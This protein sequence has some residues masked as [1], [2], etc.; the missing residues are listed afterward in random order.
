MMQRIG[1]IGLGAMGYP[2]AVNLN[3]AGFDVLGLDINADALDRFVSEGG[4]AAASLR[5]IVQHSDVVA[6]MLPTGIEVRECVHELIE[7]GLADTV[8]IDFSTIGVEGATEIHRLAGQHGIRVMDAPVS[9]GV[10]GAER[11]TL[12]VMVGGD[13]DDFEQI[14]PV[15][16]AVG[17]AVTYT[18]GP[19]CGQAVKI[20]NNMAAGIIKVAVAEAFALAQRLGVDKQ[21]LFDVASKSSANC[22]ALTTTCPV[23]GLVPSAPSSHDYEGGF[24]TRLMLKDMKLAQAAAATYGVPVALAS[25]ATSLY[26]HC[27]QAGLGDLDNSIVFKYITHDLPK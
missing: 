7:A 4:K 2:M 3:K 10:M 13:H 8:L 19:G 1:F 6:T 16:D 20:C 21:V 14:R 11:A 12:A 22:F 23:P 24:A 26:E 9:G 18:G 25:A 5:D 17:T 15:L 27:T